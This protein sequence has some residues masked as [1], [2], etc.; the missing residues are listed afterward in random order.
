MESAQSPRLP[1]MKFFHQRRECGASFPKIPQ[2]SK[3]VQREY[4]DAD[5]SN[6]VHSIHA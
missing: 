2:E 3:E 1:F 4:L 5:W 6:Y